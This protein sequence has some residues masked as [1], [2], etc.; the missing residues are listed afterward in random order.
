V[1]ADRHVY[2]ANVKVLSHVPF[3]EFAT[4]LRSAACIIGNSSATVREACYFGTPAI[5]AGNRQEGRDFNMN[6]HVF[7]KSSDK[8]LFDV[9]KN[10]RGN[11]YASNQMYGTGTAVD[12][13]LA[14]LARPT[15]PTTS[16]TF[17]DACTPTKKGLKKS[18]SQTAVA[19]TTAERL[20]VS[21]DAT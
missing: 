6:V 18:S 10:L 9:Y 17:N 15:L 20:H 21:V 13:M 19:G 7:E 3:D 12:T 5:L 11:R 2:H 1:Y 14:S 16:K 4:L 8:A